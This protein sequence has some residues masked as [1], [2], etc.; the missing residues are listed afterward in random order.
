MMK[1]KI[2][3]KITKTHFYLL[4][5]TLLNFSLKSITGI[6][7]NY[8]FAY[9]I[10][11]VI[12]A[13]GIVLFFLSFKPFK[14]I[15]IYFSYYFITL[16]LVLLFRLFGGI[17]LAILTSIIIYPIYP[18]EIE[19]ENDIIVIYTKYQGFMGICCPYE[20]TEKKYWLL[21]KKIGEINLNKVIN[22]EN[23]SV[24]SINEKLELRIQYNKY[25]YRTE[26]NI[27]T[28]TIIKFKKK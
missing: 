12:Y 8:K 26:R 5:F 16:I 28:D 13:S 3:N 7:L 24:T 6:S 10:T 21:E 27:E 19:I 2:R 18:N 20:V 9:F 15:E 4:G 17:F 22:F 1:T 23:A 14:K 11:L 25:D